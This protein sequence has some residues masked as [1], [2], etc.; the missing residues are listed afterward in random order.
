M[1]LPIT[2]RLMT[3]TILPAPG[4]SP[5]LQT[6]MS[7][8]GLDTSFWRSCKHLNFYISQ[9]EFPPKCL[10]SHLPILMNGSASCSEPF[11]RNFASVIC[12]LCYILTAISLDSDDTVVASQLICCGVTL[13]PF[14]TCWSIHAHICIL[15]DKLKF[16]S[17]A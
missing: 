4:F 1:S 3:W 14:S 12:H 2:C 8:H 17:I 10:P 9:M 5:E 16:F 7:R 6:Q 15:S 13:C 11:L